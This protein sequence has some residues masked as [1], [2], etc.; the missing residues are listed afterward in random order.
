MPSITWLHLSDFHACTPRSGWDAARVTETLVSDL[1]ELQAKEGL[2]PDLIFSTGDAA[3]G[4]IGTE[5][6]ETVAGQLEF[7]AEFLDEVR[8]VFVPDVALETL[9]CAWCGARG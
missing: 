9:R 6:G 4:E 1:E 5:P 3:F 8:A 2:R 7:F